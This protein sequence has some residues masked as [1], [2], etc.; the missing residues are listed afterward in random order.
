MKRVVLVL[1]CIALSIHAVELKSSFKFE[2]TVKNIK[3]SIKKNGYTIYAT[4][5]H[6]KNAKTKGAYSNNSVVVIFDNPKDTA[7]VM[8]HDSKVAYALPQKVMIYENL[9][10]EVIVKYDKYSDLKN[11]YK[12]KNCVILDSISN[13]INNMIKGAT[14]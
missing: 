11:S 2:K 13:K 8:M 12:V 9:D 7:R 1:V 6:K 4:I 3:Q 14:K 5:D 10:D